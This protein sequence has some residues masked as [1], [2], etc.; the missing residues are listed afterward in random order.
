MTKSEVTKTHTIQKL[1]TTSKNVEN[2][3]EYASMLLMKLCKKKKD[4]CKF[5]EM[6][7]MCAEQSLATVCR[8][9][10]GKAST[11]HF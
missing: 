4:E 6:E 10:S 3:C 9:L 11:C 5:Q 2:I 8:R 1:E 7:Q